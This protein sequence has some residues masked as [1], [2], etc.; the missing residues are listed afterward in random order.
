PVR[1]GVVG[2]S[3]LVVFDGAHKP[4]GAPAAAAAVAE[5][6]G[7]GGGRIV[8]VGM[9]RGRDPAEMLEA[10][11]ARGARTVVA[12]PPPWPRAIPESEV[13]AAAQG[14]G[15]DAVAAGSVPEAVAPAEAHAEP[16]EPGVVPGP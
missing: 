11:G 3:P 1:V 15:V 2:R 13:A 4:A 8:V 12:C 7:D 14:L 10:L 5:P 16:A 9:L 6:F